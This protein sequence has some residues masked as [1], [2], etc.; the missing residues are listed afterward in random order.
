MVDSST[1][2]IKTATRKQ[3]AALRESRL[4]DNSKFCIEMQKFREVYGHKV[5]DVEKEP[6]MHFNYNILIHAYKQ[7]AQEWGNL[8]KI[9]RNNYAL[10]ELFAE[11]VITPMLEH[12]PGYDICVVKQGLYDVIN[13]EAAVARLAYE[14]GGCAPYVGCCKHQAGGGREGGPSLFGKLMSNR[15]IKLMEQMQPVTEQPQSRCVLS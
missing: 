6:C 15:N 1:N 5:V 2:L 12:L 3:V 14:D 13:N 8:Y 7:L 9:S 11:Q 10:H 4:D